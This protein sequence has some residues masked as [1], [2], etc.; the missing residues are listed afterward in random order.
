MKIIIATDCTE[1]QVSD[2]DHLFLSAYN[3]GPDGS[4]YYRCHNC[5]IWNGN[6]IHGKRLHWFVAQLMGL[7][8]P[9]GY[10]IDH[11]DRNKLNNQRYNFRAASKRLQNQNTDMYK[12]NTSGYHGI[13]FH[14]CHNKWGATIRIN[15]KQK[16]LGYYATAEEASEIYQAAKKLRDDKEIK[17][18]EEAISE[19]NATL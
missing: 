8:V 16:H 19:N 14:K 11:I 7:E 15:N 3:W 10:Q 13:C 4:G 2:C 9:D 1:L 6:Q 17:R 18:C 12:N 5:E